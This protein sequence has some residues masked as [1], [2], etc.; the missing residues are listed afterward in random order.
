MLL[1]IG[2]VVIACCRNG[3]EA[4]NLFTLLKDLFARTDY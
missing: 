2:R 4:K 3:R 1:K